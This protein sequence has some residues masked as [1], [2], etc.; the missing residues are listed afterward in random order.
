MAVNWTEMSALVTN[1][2]DLLVT[3]VNKLPDIIVPVA[4]V[5]IVMIVPSF[6]SKITG[7]ISGLF[8]KVK[9]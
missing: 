6:A 4:I 5:I 9:L 7:K 2:M 8:D 3:L 1:G